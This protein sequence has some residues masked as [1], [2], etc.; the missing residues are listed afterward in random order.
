MFMLDL[1]IY[2]WHGITNEHQWPSFD[3]TVQVLNQKGCLSVHVQ[4]VLVVKC[5]G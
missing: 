1:H 4:N 3:S 2:R 5:E